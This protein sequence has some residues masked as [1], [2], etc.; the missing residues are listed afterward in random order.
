[1]I[2]IISICWIISAGFWLAQYLLKSKFCIRAGLLWGAYPAYEF[3]IQSTCSGDCGIRIDL[4]LVAPVV[5]IIS[6]LAV[7]AISRDYLKNKKHTHKE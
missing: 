6:S 5:F 1:M 2:L 7:L 4:L 3:W